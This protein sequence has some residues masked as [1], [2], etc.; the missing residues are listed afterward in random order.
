M[1]DKFWLMWYNEKLAATGASGQTK[2]SLEASQNVVGSEP[3]FDIIGVSGD[4][5]HDLEQSTLMSVGHVIA[6]RVPVGAFDLY[7]IERALCLQFEGDVFCGQSADEFS[8]FIHCDYLS[9]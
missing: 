9:F 4:G 5:T 1:L 8:D 2:S 7:A 6:D 3:T